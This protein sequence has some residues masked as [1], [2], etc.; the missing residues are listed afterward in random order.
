MAQADGAIVCWEAKFKHNLWRP[1]TAIQRADEDGNPLTE[2]D[3]NWEQLLGA[4]PFPSYTSGH[5]TFSKASAQVLTHFYGT[6]AL[7]FTTTG[8]G[9]PG[10]TRSFTSLSACA[11][12]VGM[13]RIYGGIHFSFDNAA[14][15]ECGGK[16]GDFVSAN[17]LLSNTEL[18][19]VRIEKT[20]AS[21]CVLRLHGIVG[22]SYVLEASSDLR[23]WTP[24]STNIAV[25]GGM[26]R[27]DPDSESRRF[28]RLKDL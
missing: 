28:Y 6:D 12:E 14:G 13:S 21:G 27:R 5:S 9:V 4:P 18:P 20:A 24:L 17:F 2:A 3:P 11:N 15:K 1:V 10:V 26:M 16:I 19:L 8:D 23:A 7:A 25:S 22:R